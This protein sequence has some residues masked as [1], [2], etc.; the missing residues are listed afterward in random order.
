VCLQ[1]LRPDFTFEPAPPPRLEIGT[2]LCRPGMLQKKKKKKIN[3]TII[4]PSVRIY[5]LLAITIWLIG[6]LCYTRAG[7]AQLIQN[8][9]CH[10]T[11]MMNKQMVG[12]THPARLL[13]NNRLAFALSYSPIHQ[14]LRRS[15]S[16]VFLALARHHRIPSSRTFSS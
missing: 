16:V 15:R 1:C 7:N 6:S 2:V 8:T 10:D 11:L 3:L 9:F 14:R 12:S 5:P 4:Y 13:R